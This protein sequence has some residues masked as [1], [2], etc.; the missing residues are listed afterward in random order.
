MKTA[1]EIAGP[2][3]VCGWFFAAFIRCFVAGEP[4]AE[5]PAEPPTEPGPDAWIGARLATETHPGRRMALRM[6]RDNDRLEES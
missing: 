6:I 3:V 1:F 4:P 2:V 5:P